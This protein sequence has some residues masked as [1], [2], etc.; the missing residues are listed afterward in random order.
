VVTLIF[1][2]VD[3]VRVA[4]GNKSNEFEVVEGLRIQP[5]RA[6]NILTLPTVF[7]GVANKQSILKPEA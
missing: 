1:S 7:T 4:V 2:F 6:R 3:E 5:M